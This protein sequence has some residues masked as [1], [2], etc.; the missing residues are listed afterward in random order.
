[1]HSIR[2]IVLNVAEKRC[3]DLVNQSLDSHYTA[4]SVTVCKKRA[5]QF[6]D[7]A[8]QCWKGYC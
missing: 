2:H 7:K 6:I 3:S 1:M 5:R 8:V 4:Q